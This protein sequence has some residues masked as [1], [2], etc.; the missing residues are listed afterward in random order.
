MKTVLDKSKIKK[1]V[2]FLCAAVLIAGIA[3]S[4][5]LIIGSFSSKLEFIHTGDRWSSD[6]SPYATIAMYTKQGEIS[7]WS[8]E[9]WVY[10]IDNALLKASVTPKEN[11]KSWIYSFSAEKDVSLTGPKS[12]VNAKTVIVRGDYFAFHPFKYT[13]GSSFLNDPS[14][15]MG[16][17]LDRNL[18]WKLFGA[19]NIIG[20]KWSVGDIEYTVV[21]IS[22]PDGDASAYNKEYGEIPRAY[23]SYAGYQ[24]IDSSLM[25]TNFEV[26]LPNSVK[27]FAKN[28]FDSQVSV[29][30]GNGIR[31]EV[32]SRFSLEN[33][34]E[35]LNNLKYSLISS[36]GIE[37][38]YWENE[39][40]IY[41][42]YSA[43][44]L[45][46]QI[47]LLVIALISLIVS[48]VFFAKS[49]FSIKKI[50]KKNR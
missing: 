17:V 44:I 22:E 40:R 21:G 4:L 28:I 3:L 34:W 16:I 29:Q 38:P 9:N 10:S 5:Q 49:G 18:A 46:L 11:A 32:S 1:S 6:K 41:D 48:V 20:M 39:A 50:I 36:N 42:Y 47:A 23:M 30:E 33:R 19:E 8:L 15:P 13:Y 24:K 2:I 43:V 45:L 25:F 35:I 14:V 26:C 7:D 37:F 12:T 31:S 27:G